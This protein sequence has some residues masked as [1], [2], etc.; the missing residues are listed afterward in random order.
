[1]VELGCGSAQ[2][3]SI[4][5]NALAARDGAAAVRFAGVDCSGAAL[6][7]AKGALLGSCPGLPPENIELVCAEYSEGPPPLLPPP[8]PTPISSL[9]F[10]GQDSNTECLE[11]F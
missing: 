2:K 7:W 11:E 3:T 9:G 10:H 5:L 4:L 8:L 1:M 6:A